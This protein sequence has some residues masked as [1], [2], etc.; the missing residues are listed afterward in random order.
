M[1]RIRCWRC[2]TEQAP[3]FFCSQC[4]AVQDLPINTDYLEVFGLPENPSID[5]AALKETWYALHRRLHPDRFPDATP[6]E[7]KASLAST[8]LLNAAW[9]TLRD[10]ERRGRWWLERNAEPLGTNNNQVPPEFAEL[11]FETQ[12]SLADHHADDA[13]SA[14][15][16]QATLNMLEERQGQELEALETDLGE[17]PEN[18][19]PEPKQERLN[20]LKRRLS[21]LSYLN[22]LVRDVRHALE[23][24]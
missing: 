20:G 14:M 6:E 1:A 22:T 23:E 2:S 12:E 24:T 7:L 3:A 5:V 9:R 13:S 4:D 8:A 19:S 11:L 16:I 15:E 21:G 18:L 17:W 10:T